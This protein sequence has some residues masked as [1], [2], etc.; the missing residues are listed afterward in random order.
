MAYYK[1]KIAAGVPYRQET[2][3]TILLIDGVDG[4]DSVDITLVS[5]NGARTSIP[6]RRTAFKY[7]QRFDSVVFEAAADCVVRV[8]LSVNEVDLGFTNGAQVQVEGQVTVTNDSDNPI[9]VSVQGGTINMTATNVGISNTNAAAVPVKNQALSNIV[10]YNVVT[11]PGTAAIALISDSTLR[12]LRIRN[13]HATAVI[14]IGGSAVTL[15]NSPIR[16]QPGEAFIED[17]AAGAA[18]YVITD[19]AGA[20]VQLQG[21]K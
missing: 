12:R 9:P 4:A 7:V 6:N 10:D 20:T 15:G 19:T 1:L 3:G 5:N 2:P 11:I 17:D 8:F 18:W 14:A 13:S 21:I 16:L